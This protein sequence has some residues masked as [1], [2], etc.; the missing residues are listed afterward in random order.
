MKRKKV[1]L[2]F[3]FVML[4]SGCTDFF[5]ICSLNPFYLE[6]NITLIPEIEGS[7]SAFPLKIKAEKPSKKDD[8]KDA[9]EIWKMADTT[10]VWKISRRITEEKIKTSKGK[11]S[12]VHKPLDFYVLKMT[13]SRADSSL[14]QFK[15]VIFKVNNQLYAD[16]V[17]ID[18]TGLDKSRMAIESYFRIHTLARVSIHDH[19]TTLSWLG[20]EYMKDMIE[21]KRVRLNYRWIDSASRLLLTGSPEQLTGMIERY[22]GEPRFIDWE[23]QPAMLK[24]NRIK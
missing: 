23:N 3:V 11:D 1:L 14:Y 15:M 10:S 16:F 22:A 12:I 21:K 13:G 17:P 2:L 24:L 4:I 7:W 8:E 19:Q 9:K 6:K 18:N 5:M 20:A